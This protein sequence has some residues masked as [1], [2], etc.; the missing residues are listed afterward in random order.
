M[1]ADYN[2]FGPRLG[3]AYDVFGNAKFVVRGGY[4]IYYHMPGNVLLMY[5]LP[6]DGAD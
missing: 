1:D 2:D 6:T 3:F 5:E 4:G